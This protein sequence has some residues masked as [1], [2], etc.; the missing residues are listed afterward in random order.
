MFLNLLTLGLFINMFSSSLLGIQFLFGA[1]LFLFQ[2]C[3]LLS[4]GFK[5]FSIQDCIVSG[6][7]W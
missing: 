6:L 1:Y 4:C 3:F 2:V 7:I 5:V